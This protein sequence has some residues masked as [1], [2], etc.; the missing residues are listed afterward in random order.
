MSTRRSFLFSVRLLNP[1]DPH[2]IPVGVKNSHGSGY[3]DFDQLIILTCPATRCLQFSL[4]LSALFLSLRSVC[5]FLG[6]MV[7]RT[8]FCFRH[9][10]LDQLF[11]F[12]M[13][14]LCT[15]N[16]IRHDSLHAAFTGYK[17][18]SFDGLGMDDIFGPTATPVAYAFSFIVG[19]LILYRIVLEQLNELAWYAAV[20]RMKRDDATKKRPVL[21]D[22]TFGWTF[23]GIAPPKWGIENCFHSLI[24]I[25]AY[26]FRYIRLLVWILPRDAFRRYILRQ[27]VTDK[28]LYD[29]ITHTMLIM[30]CETDET[31]NKLTYKCENCCKE[32]FITKDEH[33][34]CP[35]D[36]STLVLVFENEKIV[37]AR[38]ADGPVNAQ[39]WLTKNEIIC[40]ALAITMSLWAHSL[41]HVAGERCSAQIAR[42]QVEALKPCALHTFSIHDAL[43]NSPIS[44]IRAN[45]PFVAWPNRLRSGVWNLHNMVPHDLT[46]IK[47]PKKFRCYNYFLKAHGVVAKLL[48]KHKLSHLINVS[49][50]NQIFSHRRSQSTHHLSKH[51]SMTSSPLL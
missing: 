38:T 43:L 50:I 22:Y 4:F 5:W 26:T 21:F 28:L 14:H 7:S 49:R 41:I 31:G 11:L 34:D 36:G 42:L 24:H 46:R 44:A 39:K 3:H 20:D 29:F 35:I 33:I 13:R 17:P 47:T 51:R 16:T 1:T 8:S 23:I 40:D 45:H 19:I 6:W 2:C 25:P 32:L 10:S 37:E 27:R 12:L 15:V 18:P 48:K 9:E 30:L